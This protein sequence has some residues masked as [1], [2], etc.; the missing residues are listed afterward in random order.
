MVS[1]P[2]VDDDRLALSQSF[3]VRVWLEELGEG[4]TEWRGK[5]QCVANGEVLYFRNWQNLIDSF[6]HLLAPPPID[7]PNLQP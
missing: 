3:V 1:N 5:V 6:Q 7:A 2:R 4:K